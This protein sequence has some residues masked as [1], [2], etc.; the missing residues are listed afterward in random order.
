M[1]E[2][3]ATYASG[4]FFRKIE[5]CEIWRECLLIALMSVLI[6]DA[7]KALLLPTS[8]MPHI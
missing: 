1:N 8:C 7:G 5:W 4:K 3:F 2:R 6:D